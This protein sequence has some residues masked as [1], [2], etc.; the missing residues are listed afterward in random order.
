MSGGVPREGSAARPGERVPETR[1]CVYATAGWGI[2]D[3]RWLAALIEL[4]F[5]P[6]VV[7]LGRDVASTEEL[8]DAVALAAE[9]RRPVLAGPLHTVTRPLAELDLTLVGLSW[10]YDLAEGLEGDLAWL[11]DLNGLIVDSEANR[12]VALRAGLPGERITLLP[13]GIDL[14]TF[15]LRPPGADLRALDIPTEARVVLSLRAHEHSYRVADI[16]RAF[17]LLPSADHRPDGN[18][19]PYLVIGHAGSLTEDLRALAGD[20]GISGRVRFIGTVPEHDLVPLLGRAD[21]YV[22]AS[23]VDGTSVTLLQAMACGAPVVASDTPGNLGWVE[24][25]VTGFTFPTGDIEALSSVMARV[26]AEH[27]A[28]VITR[29]RAQVEQSAD[30]QANLP[31][32]RRAMEAT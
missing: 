3:D 30:W 8:Q 29:A 10:G 13:W 5:A 21:C 27:P 6:T 32:L 19:E 4:G 25:E 2:H 11:P 23:Q 28:E 24:D 18:P 15:V 20:L 7:S 26:L 9:G 31:R 12:E 22:T 1:E 17:A 16:V 14:S